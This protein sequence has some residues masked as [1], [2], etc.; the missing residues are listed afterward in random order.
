MVYN[1]HHDHWV[2]SYVDIK[3]ASQNTPN[4]TPYLSHDNLDI[5]IV[6]S[7]TISPTNVSPNISSITQ[8]NEKKIGFINS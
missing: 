5:T 2:R 6:S 4:N 7:K 8:K 3:S 1:H